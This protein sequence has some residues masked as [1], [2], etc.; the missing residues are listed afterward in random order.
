MNDYREVPKC[1]HYT[2]YY[3]LACL[4]LLGDAPL[5]VLDLGWKKELRCEKC[6]ITLGH[7]ILTSPFNEL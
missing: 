7:F 5:T 4:V 2:G 3:R 6:D 1:Q